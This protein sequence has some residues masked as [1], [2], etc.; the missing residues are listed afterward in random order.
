VRPIWSPSGSSLRRFSTS[1]R[2]GQHPVFGRRHHVIKARLAVEELKEL[3]RRKPAIA[4]DEEARPRKR[5]PRPRRQAAQ[6][7][8]RAPRGGRVARPEDRRAEIMLGLVIEGQKGQQREITVA[9]VMPIEEGGLL[10]PVRRISGRVE[11]DRDGGT[12]PPSR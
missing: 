10:R 9:I 3:R 12:R 11:I 8:P 4:G 6:Q 1:P 2:A 5:E 7:P